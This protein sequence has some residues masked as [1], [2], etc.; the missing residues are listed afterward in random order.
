MMEVDLEQQQ[1]GKSKKLKVPL[2]VIIKEHNSHMNL[3]DI[4]DQSKTTY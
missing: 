4:H 3:V 1:K 2:P